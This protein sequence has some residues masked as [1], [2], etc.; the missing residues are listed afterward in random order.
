LSLKLREVQGLRVLE[1]RVL[2]RTFGPKRVKMMEG[3]RRM[4]NE[5]LRNLYALTNVI[6]EIK[7]RRL[8]LAGH[9]ARME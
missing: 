7:S 2:R 6:M 1:N 3:W 8:K 4:H 9:V 5:E